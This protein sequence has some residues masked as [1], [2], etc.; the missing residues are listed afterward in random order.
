[1]SMV[2]SPLL[3][4][5]S[6]SLAAIKHHLQSHNH[7]LLTRTFCYTDGM[8]LISKTYYFFTPYT[9]AREQAVG[10]FFK[11][12]TERSRQPRVQRKL[13]RLLQQNA[14]VINLW[15]E[16][17]YK[18]YSYLN[19][20]ER[21]KLYS[22][23]QLITDDFNRYY[24][25]RGLSDDDE[26]MALLKTLMAYFSP[27]RGLYAYR[28][29]SSFG[30]LLRDPTHEKLIGDCNQI[31]TL[32][33]YLYSQYY[34]IRDLQ[35]RELPEHVA[36]H[37]NGTDIETT[38]GRFADY[39]RRKHSRLLPI[40]EIVSINLLDTTDSY[41][42]KHEVSPEDFLQASRLAFIVSTNRSIVTRNLKAAYVR[43]I[44]SLMKRNDYSRA[45]KLAAYSR[46]KTLLGI[47]GHNGAA[48]EM[49]RSNYTAAQR[50][51]KHAPKR[52]QLIR[53]CYEGM[54]FEEQKKLG[55]NLTTDSLKGY[56]STIKRMR[57]YAKKSHNKKLVTYVNSLYKLL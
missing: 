19:K 43:L 22:N 50:F 39:S 25:P 21:Q 54:F 17:R 1:M 28:E 42:S 32:Y 16:H 18:G 46:D 48:Y 9:D 36:L 30:R 53:R 7:N 6:K 5:S 3:L 37:Y 24:E 4:N 38:A 23:L 45:L 57:H 44:N 52:E 14:A 27:R 56:A 41:L 12:L 40:Q 8:G 26:R 31:V 29:S 34:D 13:L 15:T 20:T 2:S 49:G 10:R 33:I 47:V 51:A 35:I 11:R 55:T